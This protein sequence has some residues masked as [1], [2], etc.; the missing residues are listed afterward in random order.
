MIGYPHPLIWYTLRVISFA[1]AIAQ[2]KNRLGTQHPR[3]Q[4]AELLGQIYEIYEQDYKKQ[5]WLEYLAWLKANKYQHSA[6]TVAQYKKISYPKISISSFCS[7][8]LSPIPTDDLF[9][10]LSE[11]KDIRNRNGSFNKWL[12]YNLKVVKDK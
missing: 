4:R 8:W 6:K 5:K 7:Y 2:Q 1:D 12:F 11:A 10:I 9:Y 3:S